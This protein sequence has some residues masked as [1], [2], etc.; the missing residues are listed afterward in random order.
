[1]NGF[2][3]SSL[4]A[5]AKITYTSY[6]PLG[7]KYRSFPALCRWSVPNLLRAKMQDAIRS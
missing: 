5:K 7:T 6:K 2:F 4:I 3:G 1:M